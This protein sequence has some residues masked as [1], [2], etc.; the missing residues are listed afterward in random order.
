[1]KLNLQVPYLKA[2]LFSI[3]ANIPVDSDRK[4]LSVSSPLWLIFLWP[5]WGQ[6]L[7]TT[8][9]YVCTVY[10]FQFQFA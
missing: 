6:V 8:K 2:T 10:Q 1:M 7:P 9:M 3:C 4:S 5:C